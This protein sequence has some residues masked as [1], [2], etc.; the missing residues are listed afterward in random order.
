MNNDAEAEIDDGIFLFMSQ[1]GHTARKLVHAVARSVDA[2]ICGGRDVA[3][4]CRKAA[5]KITST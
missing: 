3:T 5:R 2:G 1:G 4:P